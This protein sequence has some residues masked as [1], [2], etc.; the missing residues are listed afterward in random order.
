MCVSWSKLSTILFADGNIGRHQVFVYTGA[1]LTGQSTAYIYR[2]KQ[3]T[4]VVPGE[5]VAWVEVKE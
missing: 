4:W 2:N 1:C 5:S 3:M